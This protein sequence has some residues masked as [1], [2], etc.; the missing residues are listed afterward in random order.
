MRKK[1]ENRNTS[2]QMCGYGRQTSESL[3]MSSF[4]LP[5]LE[6]PYCQVDMSPPATIYQCR[7]GHNLC[8]KCKKLKNMKVG[9]TD[10][11]KNSQTQNFH[12]YCQVCP[13]CQSGFTGRNSA[14]EDV[15]ALV[16]GKSIQKDAFVPEDS[17]SFSFITHIP[18]DMEDD[19]TDKIDN[20]EAI[21][22]MLVDSEPCAAAECY[23]RLRE[24]TNVREIL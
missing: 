18:E 20:K 22:D 6:C 3:S 23:C 17:Q 21:N 2:F 4:L 12:V 19:G 24:R 11:A 9:I 7:E 1:K 10:P 13:L 5:L 16:F 15:A 14:V 8:S